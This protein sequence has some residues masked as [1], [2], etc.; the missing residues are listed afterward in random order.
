M[1]TQNINQSLSLSDME[2]MLPDYAF[3][4]LDEPEKLI[5]ESHLPS[6]PDIKK[7]I[8]EVQRV[9]ER[10]DAMDFNDS[11][12]YMSRNLSVRVLQRMQ[13]NPRSEKSFARYMKLI[14]LPSFR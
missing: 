7:E 5:F 9:F 6:F 14:A 13:K 2:A 3:G 8:I 10:I 12:D 4:R 11:M 1:N